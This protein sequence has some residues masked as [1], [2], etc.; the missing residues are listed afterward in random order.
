LLV[1]LD[2]EWPA[3]H[4]IKTQRLA[5]RGNKVVQTLPS[6]QDAA[7]ELCQDL[8]EFL[9]R[10]YPQV[11]KIQRPAKDNLGWYGEGSVTKIEMPAHDTSYDLLTEDLLKAS[12]SE[13]SLH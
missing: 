13:W 9:S 3:Y 6:A 5:D 1:Q 10:R 8:C 2:N 12:E 7:Y 11:C 4:R